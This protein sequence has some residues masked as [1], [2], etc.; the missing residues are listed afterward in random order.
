MHRTDNFF[1]PMLKV[2]AASP[3]FG[4]AHSKPVSITVM[5]GGTLKEEQRV[6]ESPIS[7]VVSAVRKLWDR[8]LPSVGNWG[9]RKFWIGALGHKNKISRSVC[10]VGSYF[11]L[12]HRH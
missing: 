10:S 5:S 3:T 9:D 12:C 7:I 2:P 1:C 8:T 4:Y 11:N 6:N